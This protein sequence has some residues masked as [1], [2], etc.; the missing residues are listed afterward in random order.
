[1]SRRSLITS[2]VIVGVVLGVTARVYQW[3]V[4]A[5]GAEL[6]SELVGLEKNIRTLEKYNRKRVELNQELKGY[7]ARTLGA[8]AEEVEHK[9]SVLL[10]EV[11]VA[12]GLSGLT[13]DSRAR[14]AALN[15]AADTIVGFFERSES[16]RPD[17]V[18]VEGTLVGSG[19]LEQVTGA[20]D[21]NRP[22]IRVRLRSLVTDGDTV[23]DP[24]PK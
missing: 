17:F 2:L 4:L 23:P 9:L 13:V 11:G 24:E 1:M 21:W 22:E 19:S 10:H 8:T 18:V 12:H 14:R 5:P 16:K 20:R 6:K 7:E 15:P 3:Q